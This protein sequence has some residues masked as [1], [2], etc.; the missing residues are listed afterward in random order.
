MIKSDG[1]LANLWNGID[2]RINTA[3]DYRA[4]ISF[5]DSSG[6]VMTD[7]NG[8]KIESIYEFKVQ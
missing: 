7:L 2:T 6:L 8:R 3:G 5:V 1:Y 4:V